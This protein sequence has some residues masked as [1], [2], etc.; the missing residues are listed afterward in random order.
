[1]SKR[2]VSVFLRNPKYKG[3]V[4]ILKKICLI[5]LAV[6]LMFVT[7]NAMLGAV[8]RHVCENT[9]MDSPA[10]DNL[11]CREVLFK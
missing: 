3:T 1:M 4:S 8:D 6:G 11:H 2:K 10:F 7:I 5:A 9:R